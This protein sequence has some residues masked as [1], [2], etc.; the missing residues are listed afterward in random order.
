MT[1]VFDR[2]LATDWQ[3][4]Y[5]CSAN[6][7]TET[8]ISQIL[9]F[10]SDPALISFS[11]GMPA[12]ELFPIPEFQAAAQRVLERDGRK[13]L[14]YG[15][16]LGDPDLRAAIAE[17]MQAQGM[18]ATA[19]NILIVNGSQQALD[20][21]GRLFLDPNDVVLT[22]N[23]T[24][25]GALQSWCSY[26]ARYVTLPLDAEGMQLDQLD[27]ML[28]AHRPKF[29]YV[30]P[31]F[32]NPAGVTLEARRR[33]QLSK[34]TAEQRVMVVEDDP[35][36]E[37]R[38]EGE[39]PKPIVALG[40]DHV[41]YLST[42]S[43]TLSPGLRL[44]WIIAPQEII[45]KLAQIKQVADLHTSPLVQMI[46]LE[47]Y[48]SDFYRPHV[49]RLCAVYR[50]RRDVMLEAM[51]EYFPGAVTW[52]KPEGGLFLWVELP[53]GA[54]AMDL[55]HRAL[56]EKVAFVPGQVFYPNSGGENAFRL[57]FSVS[58]PDTIR[59]GVKRLGLVLHQALA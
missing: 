21:L 11:G 58:Q 13:A 26:G 14:Q 55:M 44:G 30:L 36:G 10:M 46:A 4:C 43:K 20:L 33:E 52:E 42:F 17:N 48:Q 5:S 16:T 54:D 18:G 37:L 24:Y 57:N 28:E 22:G 19:E 47:L 23:P 12:P 3:S 32:H 49:Q 38:Y 50:E 45:A 1:D 56:E 31:N 29:V 35:Y 59:E 6:R 39:T 15:T 27:V 2:G 7:M 25:L 53:E 51:E 9:K 8:I 34:V 40:S 41:I